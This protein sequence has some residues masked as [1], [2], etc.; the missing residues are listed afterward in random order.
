MGSG[1]SAK[2]QC[3]HTITNYDQI[4]WYRQIKDRDLTFIGY[5]MGNAD[6]GYE[7]DFKTKVEMTGDGKKNVFLTIK[8]LLSN[9]SAVYFCAA[10]YTVL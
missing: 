1:E 6:G 10:Y 7:P 2:I 4:N 9:D 5:K 8:D 3:V